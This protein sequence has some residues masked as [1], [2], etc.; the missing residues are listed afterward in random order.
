M[1]DKVYKIRLDENHWIWSLPKGERS[2]T[3]RNALE[4][5]KNKNNVL[6]EIKNL[7]EELKKDI[8][9]V[10]NESKNTDQQTENISTKKRLAASKK[11]WLGTV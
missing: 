3:V 5:Y 4:F 7:L 9:L 2:V 8:K 6:E 11:E 1:T 10:P